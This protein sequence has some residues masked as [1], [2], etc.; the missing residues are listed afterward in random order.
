[1][2]ELMIGLVQLTAGSLTARALQEREH[3]L[4]AQALPPP[5]I[6]G[7]YDKKAASCAMNVSRRLRRSC[8][9]AASR[10]SCLQLGP[11][12]PTYVFRGRG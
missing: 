12:P 5:I 10:I 4:A 1:M 8:V 2:A 7:N 3:A 9:R 11:P 6:P